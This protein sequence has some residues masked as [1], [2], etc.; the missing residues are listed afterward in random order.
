[1]PDAPTLDPATTIL[2]LM[3]FQPGIVERF[4]QGETTMAAA[5]RALQTARAVGMHVG[6]VRVGLTP[7]EIEALPEHA[8]MHAAVARSAQGIR[9]DA[10]DTQVHEAIAPRDG[11]L[12]VRKP[13]VGAFAAPEFEPG[14]R[15]RGVDTVVLTGLS[16]SGVVLSTLRRAADEDFRIVVLAD[17]VWDPDAEA[18]RVLLENVFPKQ[19]HV[20]TVDAFGD[21]IAG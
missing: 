21:L 11:D 13:R 12:V 16:T 1:V 14:L 17:A 5:A 4:P 10:P 20:T 3:D 9:A 8:P 15:E 6:Y 19:A 18:H 7:E 2:L